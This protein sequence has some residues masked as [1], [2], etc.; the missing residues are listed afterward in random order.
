ML[1]GICEGECSYIECLSKGNFEVPFMSSIL[2]EHFGASFRASGSRP[3][4]SNFE[5]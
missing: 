4:I 3:C 1:L 2:E 5:C